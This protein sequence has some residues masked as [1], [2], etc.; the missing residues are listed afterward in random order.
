MIQKSLNADNVYQGV[1]FVKMII[2]FVKLA[3]MAFL[4]IKELV[5]LARIFV[6][7]VQIRIAATCVQPI[8]S[9]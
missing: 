5:S 8:L 3:V 7:L 1:L 6:K 9:L 2:Q 4:I